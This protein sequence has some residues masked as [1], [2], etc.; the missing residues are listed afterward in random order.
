[1]ANLSRTHWQRFEPDL[2][3]N[4]QTDPSNRLFLE[5]AD[6]MTK[7]E[8]HD[9]TDALA[10]SFEVPEQA[11]LAGLVKDWE[12]RR[13]T[14][15]AELV[16]DFTARLTEAAAA[17]DAAYVA[18]LAEAWA[19]F[20]RL[21]AGEH[22]IDGKPLAGLGGYLA[23]VHGQAGRFNFLELQHE[24][25]RLNSVEGT[26]ALFSEPPAGGPSSTPRASAAK[27]GSQTGG[28]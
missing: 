26:R 10:R 1:M 2:G 6:R 27:E 19:P 18:K 24:V 9:F 16:V 28:R 14:L 17:R 3:D 11:A 13:D 4:L 5:V 23:F 22:A 20:I 12:A 8:L 7:V 15:T 25:Q 21:G